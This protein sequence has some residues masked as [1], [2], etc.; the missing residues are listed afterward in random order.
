MAPICAVSRWRT[1]W[2][3]SDSPPEGGWMS[4]GFEAAKTKGAGFVVSSGAGAVA[5]AVVLSGFRGLHADPASGAARARA[6]TLARRRG[7]EPMSHPFCLDLST[8]GAEQWS[9]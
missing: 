2:M 4:R 9:H 6:R 3:T 8:R 7:R 5:D 1:P